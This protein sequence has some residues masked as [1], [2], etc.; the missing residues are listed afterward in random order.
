M[1]GAVRHSK[2]CDLIN[3]GQYY[4]IFFTRTFECN[5]SASRHLNCAFLVL[6]ERSHHALSNKPKIAQIQSLETKIFHPKTLPK[7]RYNVSQNWLQIYCAT[8]HDIFLYLTG[9]KT[10]TKGKHLNI[11]SNTQSSREGHTLDIKPGNQTARKVQ[12]HHYRI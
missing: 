9:K 5:I 1:T 2:L 7:L 3:S 4:S 8:W 11:K 6:L 12:Q 10:G